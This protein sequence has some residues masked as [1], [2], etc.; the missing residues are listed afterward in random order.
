MPAKQTLPPVPPAAKFPAF[1]AVAGLFFFITIIKFGSPVI[2]D[3]YVEAPQDASSIIYDSWPPLWGGWFFVPLAVVGLFAVGWKRLRMNCVLA[4]PLLWLGW[5]FVAAAH[6]VQPALTALTLKHFVVCV[7]L[8]YLGRFATKG[9]S[10]PW[11]LWVGMGLAL[12]W[13]IRMG[14]EQHFGGL[15][16]TR[17]MLASSPYLPGVRMD[18]LQDPEYQ[19]RI[20]SNRIFGSFG[21]YPN[22]FAGGLV[23]LL[24]LT[25][26]FLW[27]LTPKVRPAIRA[28]FVLI[29]GGCG[30]GC[31]YWSGSKAGWLVALAM[32]LI[33]LGHSALPLR[34]KRLLIYG[35]LIVG[36][37]GF[38]FKYAAFF[39]KERNSVSARFGYWRAALIITD[40]HPWFGTGPGTFQVPYS[41]IMRPA[42][43]RIKRPADE[44]ARLCHNDYLEQATDSGVFGLVSYTGMISAFLLILYR[45]S[46]SKMPL[47]WL[48]MAI[49][50]G[51]FGLSLHSLVEFHLYIPALAWPTF[52]LFGWLGAEKCNDND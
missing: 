21:G 12:C 42:D 23:L 28:V 31:L 27:R 25:L 51:L 48:N 43:D 46:T 49:W 6:S 13:V 7:S 39:Q 5:Q 36:V 41:R 2:L 45:Y 14:L 10:N 24:P 3:R 1:A 16:A 18:Q 8:F 15:E 19:K 4:L 47:N 17:K 26:V 30:L 32:G 50:I 44:M 33:A 11:P 22:A 40:R 38:A 52:F 9:M 29:L 34:W 20:A 35:V 37:A